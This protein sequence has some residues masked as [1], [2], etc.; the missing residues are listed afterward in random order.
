MQ[1]DRILKKAVDK[2]ASDVH[3]SAQI[4]PIMRLNTQ[5]EQLDNTIFSNDEMEQLALYILGPEAYKVYEAAG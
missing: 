2:D 1:L 4:A 3:L 5:L